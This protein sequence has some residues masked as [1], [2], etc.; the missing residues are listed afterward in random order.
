MTG[1]PII[2][3]NNIFIIILINITQPYYIY[4]NIVI[5]Y[6]IFKGHDLVSLLTFLQDKMI[7]RMGGLT[8]KKVDVRVIAANNLDL[9]TLA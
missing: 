7:N 8:L 9:I 1:T 3:G 6:R 4:K 2:I 5:C